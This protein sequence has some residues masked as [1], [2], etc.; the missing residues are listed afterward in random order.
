MNWKKTRWMEKKKILWPPK[1]HLTTRVLTTTSKCT[2]LLSNLIQRTTGKLSFAQQNPSNPGIIGVLKIIIKSYIFLGFDCRFSLEDDKTSE[3]WDL[4]VS[5]GPSLLGRWQMNHLH[6]SG[7]LFP[8]RGIPDYH[9][10]NLG[11]HF[12]WKLSSIQIRKK[13]KIVC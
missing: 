11:R 9:Q 5:E 4:H 2:A 6:V 8:A 7:G 12:V 10:T 1:R 3:W 13:V